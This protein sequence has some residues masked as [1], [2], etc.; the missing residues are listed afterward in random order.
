MRRCVSLLGLAI[1]MAA[2]F[3]VLGLGERSSL[4]GT[5]PGK[6]YGHYGPADIAKLDA[7]TAE[8]FPVQQ[9]IKS[10]GYHANNVDEIQDLLPP[11][12][13]SIAR[14]PEIWGDIR[15]NEVAFRPWATWGKNVDLIRAATEKY[16]GQPKI[17]AK[18]HIRNYRAGYPFPNSTNGLE[19]AWDFVKNRVTGDAFIQ[20]AGTATSCDSA[21][22]RRY[23]VQE[24]FSVSLNGR[25]W[26]H[27]P[28]W[29][30]NP[31]NI[32][33][34]E[35]WGS[36]SPYDIRGLV[37]LTYRYDD[38]D[39]QDEQWIYFPTMRRVRRMSTAQRWDRL[40]G[41]LDIMYDNLSCFN[42][43]LTNYTWKYLGRKV[44][45]A[46]RN[47]DFNHYSSVKDKPAMG[48]VDA[49]YS[50]VNT[51][52]LEYTPK[53][54]MHAPI[55]R[56][57]MYID[58]DSYMGYYAEFWDDQGRPWQFWVSTQYI[59]A[60]GC[61]IAAD[62]FMADLQRTHATNVHGSHPKTGP[63]TVIATPEFM[64]MDNLRAYFGGR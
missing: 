63:D 15:I 7:K 61:Q 53:P 1:V 22:Q 4:A 42:G 58:P 43:K 45:L 31:H 25:L 33:L 36:F 12:L 21:G 39:R 9:V 13:Y 32:D 24:I 8:G 35:T 28:L 34:M 44:L 2:V 62:G 40:P 29:T 37:P 20:T 10:W 49:Q 27:A 64:T 52:M 57:L 60:N 38:P 54:Y 56:A 51:I 5:Y 23:M 11:F 41:G 48:I 14:H 46:P 3:F 47:G 30:P 18:G 50:R 19:L 59:D 55:S 26:T 6:W 16:K 17:D